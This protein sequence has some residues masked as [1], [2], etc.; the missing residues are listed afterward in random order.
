MAEC[1]LSTVS[2][3]TPCSRASR[4]TISPAMTRISLDATAMSFPARIAARAGANPAVPTMAM[5]TMS[6]AGKVASLTNPSVPEKTSVRVPS[7]FRSSRAFAGSVMEMASGRCLCVCSSSS[8]M[9]FPAARPSRRI[10]SGK[11]CATLMVLVPMDPVLPSRT[12]LR[13]CDLRFTIYETV[14]VR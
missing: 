12:T 13:I 1:S 6:A 7:V 3:F 11:S 14:H 9:L 10:R 4:M 8:S 2:T 5:S